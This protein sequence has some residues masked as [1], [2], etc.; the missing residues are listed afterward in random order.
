LEQG[1]G[2]SCW[3]RVGARVGTGVVGAGDL[4]MAKQMSVARSN[5]G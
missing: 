2:R 5:T 1:L 3:T 4:R